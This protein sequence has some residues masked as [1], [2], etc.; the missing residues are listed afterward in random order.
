M[1]AR[2]CHSRPASRPA[3]TTALVLLFL[4]CAAVILFSGRGRFRFGSFRLRAGQLSAASVERQHLLSAATHHHLLELAVRADPH[5]RPIPAAGRGPVG[6]DEP[7][8][9]DRIS[10]PR[11]GVFL[12]GYFPDLS[13]YNR[14]QD[15]FPSPQS[16]DGF[17]RLGATHLTYNCAFEIANGH[18]EPVCKGI[19][20]VLDAN[21]SLELVASERWN[22]AQAGLYRLK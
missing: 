12:R 19:I 15:A 21:P 2:P 6:G 13:D 17:R 18:S 4:G 22:G 5:R 1:V 14:A 20:A 16:I 3:L 9:G 10:S 8:D 11:P 7:V